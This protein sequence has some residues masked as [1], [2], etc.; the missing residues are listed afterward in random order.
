M[1]KGLPSSGMVQYLTTTS[2]SMPCEVSRIFHS[3]LVEYPLLSLVRFAKMEIYSGYGC[4]GNPGLR[5]RLRQRCQTTI[6]L[7][8][9]KV[10]IV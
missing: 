5:S 10:E 3:R 8:Y 7:D 6:N 2:D 9:I 4:G 1:T